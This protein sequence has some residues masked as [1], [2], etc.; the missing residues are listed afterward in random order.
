MKTKMEQFPATNPNPVLS[1]TKDGTVLYSNVAGE[2]LLHEWG[3]GVGEKLP[4]YIEDFVQR[5]ISLNSPKKME[6]NVGKKV[7]LVDFHPIPEE[8]CVNIYGFDISDQKELEE[9]KLRESEE[10]LTEVQKLAHIGNWKWNI[11]TNELCWSDEVYRIFG[12]NPQEFKATFDAYFN[13]V[14]PDDRDYLN[15]AIK[16]AFKGEPYSVDNRIITAN[17]EER[18][19]HTDAKFTFNED[20]IP[21]YA[22]GIVQDITE[23]KQIEKTLSESS[24]KVAEAVN[25]ERQRLFDV[26]ETLPA[27]ICLLT[28]DYHVAFANRS[29]RERFGESGGRHCYEYCFGRTKPCEFCESYKVLETGQPHRWEVTAPNGSV[30]DAYDFPFTDVD[31]SPMILEMDIDI[32]EQKKTE[33]KLKD[34]LDSLDKLVKERTSELEEAYKALMESEKS[35]AEAQRMAHLGNWDW[36]LVTGEVYWSDEMYRIFG[37]NPQESGATYDEF[38]SY[39]HPDYRDRVNNTVK[40]ALNG[41]PL[42]GDYRIIL[43]NGE[44]RSVNTQAEVIFDEKNT[45]IRIR[46]T[47]QDITE[48]KQTQLLMKADL[49]ALTRMH[50]LSR[51]LL[52]AEGIQPL[53]QE[54]M[55]A[56]VAIVDAKMGTLQLIEDDSLLIV[57]HYGH[58]QPFLEF[59]SSA[60]SRASVCG[61]AMQRGG[62]VIIEDVETSS[63]FVG[64]PSLDVM[65]NAGVRAVHST[66]IISRAGTLL[67]VLTTQWD[68]PYSLSEHDLWRID[69][70]ARQ[71][72]DMIEQ[73]RSEEALRESETRL[74]RFYESGIFGVFYYNMDGSITEA[75]KK[76]LEMVGY[77]RED[78]QAGRIKWDKM[79]PLEYR[80]LEEYAIAELKATGMA[81]PYEKEYI[82]K[83][84]SRISIILGVANIDEARDDG[85]AFVL[86][87]TER[88]KAEE[89]LAKIEIARKQEIH[90]RI[91]NNLQVISSLLD[92]Q[93]EQFKDRDDIKDSEVLQAF[94]ESQDRVISMALIHEELYKGGG[95]DTLGFSSYIEELAESLFLTY[96]LGNSDIGLNMDL[97]KN[98]FFDMD[99]AIPLGII[100]NELVSNSLKHA[101]IGKDEG[102]VRIKLRREENGER[103]K[104]G[105]E[106]T[107]FI[108]TIS[109]NGVGIPEFDIEDLDSLGM[110]LVTSLVDQ[111]DGELELKRNNGTKFTM[112]FTVTEK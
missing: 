92:L 76:F 101:F 90:H 10:D 15:N 106:S 102:E 61:E 16:K 67:G 112:K 14:H 70:L 74:R 42:A 66:P 40:K 95:F 9:G 72:A 88:K 79:T 24:H 27:M 103:R 108:L 91:K 21:V 110:Q 98:L 93:A 58:Q 62:R 33:A 13:Y 80:P 4:S 109:D 7:Y 46:G 107:S 12:L 31:G 63:L 48:R 78:L 22:R 19:V 6:V 28:P 105:C 97:E 51:K 50:A 38:L 18:T 36:N 104:E 77:T 39:V 11:V 43:A 73:A 83:N 100:V 8:E 56:A 87:I 111:L 3:V 85:I 94:R 65:C 29:F 37:R 47:V 82:H 53:L 1:V 64:T 30:I 96:R 26:L 32:T 57:A 84:G 59:F 54:I 25:T 44:E 2:P 5:V 49:E 23:R 34:T 52:G 86:D 69:L 68:V 81:T 17:G 60:E 75:N 89:T 45:P 41:D 71:A 35:L 99:T 55:D 20:N